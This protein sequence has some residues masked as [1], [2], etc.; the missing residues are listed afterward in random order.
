MVGNRL[1]AIPTA[2]HFLDFQLAL[3]KFINQSLEAT[4]AL[5][6]IEIIAHDVLEQ[7]NFERHLVGDVNTNDDGYFGKTSVLGRAPAPLAGENLEVAC[8]VI[9]WTNNNW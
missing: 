1:S 8:P 4:S 7:P 6:W 5:H 3:S 2:H 9:D